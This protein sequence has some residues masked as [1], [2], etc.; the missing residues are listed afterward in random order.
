MKMN[1]VQVKIC[2]VTSIDDAKKC[3]DLG[4]DMIGLNF[5]RESPRY[6]EPKIA[7]KIIEAVVPRVC[8]VG[9]FVERT[10]NEV[11]KT[12]AVAD[13]RSSRPCRQ[14][15]GRGGPAASFATVGLSSR[16]RARA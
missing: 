16:R 8:A 6:V 12:A 14:L 1:R 9:V 5:C 15:L 3:A 11:R 2:G 4:V 13:L 10:I 7:R